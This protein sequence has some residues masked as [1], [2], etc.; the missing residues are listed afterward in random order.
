M[1]TLFGGIP[2]SLLIERYLMRTN[3]WTYAAKAVLYPAAAMLLIVIFIWMIG[4]PVRFLFYDTTGLL[5]VL[6][7]LLQSWVYFV[8]YSIIC[9][10]V[11]RSLQR[12]GGLEE[13]NEFGTGE[14][15]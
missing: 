3:V 14:Q 2:S 10:V 11:R 6:P 7:A 8:I 1:F 13:E 12:C 15:K 4:G 5:F 9:L